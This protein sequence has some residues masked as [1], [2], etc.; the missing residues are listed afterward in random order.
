MSREFQVEA[1]L[2]NKQLNHQST[3]LVIPQLTRVRVHNSM[4][5]KVNLDAVGLRGV[6]MCQLAKVIVRDLGSLAHGGTCTAGVCGGVEFKC[7]LTKLV[8]IRP[9][10][11]Q[12]VAILGL[13]KPQHAGFNNK[14]IVVLVLV[15]LR[16]QYYYLPAEGGTVAGGVE[17][18]AKLNRVSSRALRRL[19]G[20]FINDYRKVKS[21]SLAADCWS[22]SV[23]KRVELLH[24][25]EVVDW[26]CTK[27]EIWG[28][29]LG[30][31]QWCNIFDED[32]GEDGED[33]DGEDS[34]DEDSDS[35]SDGDSDSTGSHR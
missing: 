30:I 25:D 1:N 2:S 7:L 20:H 17:Q 27:N 21:F 16:A 14:Y 24:V 19:F 12:V 5:Y 23:E 4:Y 28:I 11:R 10:W 18:L 15:Y 32:S 8:H 9:T 6:N 3:S 33:S 13:G 31:C 26:L 34:D 35:D 29:P 22:S